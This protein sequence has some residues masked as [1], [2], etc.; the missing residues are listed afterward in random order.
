MQF[1]FSIPEILHNGGVMV[2]A[3]N[4]EDPDFVHRGPIV[5]APS[6]VKIALA[7]GKLES[8]Y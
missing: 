2:Y 4:A 3:H 8:T 6:L 5:S 1:F 7:Y